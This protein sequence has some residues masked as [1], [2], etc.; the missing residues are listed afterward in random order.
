[1]RL[2]VRVCVCAVKRMAKCDFKLEM[3]CKTSFHISYITHH[4]KEHETEL[5]FVWFN[6]SIHQRH[7]RLVHR[8]YYSAQ[9]QI[10]FNSFGNELKIF[11]TPNHVFSMN[12]AKYENIKT[13]THKNR[14][15]NRVEASL[16][17]MVTKCYIEAVG[18]H[19]KLCITLLRVQLQN[20]MQLSA[21]SQYVY[22]LN[23]IPSQTYRMNV[24]FFKFHSQRWSFT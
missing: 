24:R 2:C 23:E 6:F 14:R 10:L 15:T 19:E 13:C 17:L 22:N 12:I 7:K 20:H 3:D 9:Q 16:R 5:S 1:M 18:I 4:R 8:R 21:S 11:P